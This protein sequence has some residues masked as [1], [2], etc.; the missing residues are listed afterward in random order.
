MREK[1]EKEPSTE[2]NIILKEK[3]ASYTKAFIQA[4]R[5]NW[6]R[7]TESLNMEKDGEKLW[8]LAKAMNDEKP[9]ATPI[10]LKDNEKNSYGQASC[11]LSHQQLCKNQQHQCPKK[12]R[13]RGVGKTE[14][15]KKQRH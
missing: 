7:K 2:N 3:I 1:A 5:T 9:S 6:K 14:T 12:Q 15:L 11:R 10:S 8:K 13:E 4:A